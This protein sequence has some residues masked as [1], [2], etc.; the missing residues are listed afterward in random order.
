MGIN[1]GIIHNAEPLSAEC[2]KELEKQV[3]ENQESF[4]YLNETSE[5]C[6]ALPC[7]PALIKY[8]AWDNAYEL[9]TEGTGFTKK[10]YKKT[11]L[12]TFYLDK[13]LSKS[14]INDSWCEPERLEGDGQ[15]FYT[16]APSTLSFRSPAPLNELQDVQINGQTVDPSNYELEE[17]STIVKLKHDYL[18]ALENGKYEVAIISDSMTVKGDFT[19]T[20]PELNEYGFY[21]NQPYFGDCFRNEFIIHFGGPF[22]IMFDAAG[23]A[24]LYQLDSSNA[25]HTDYKLEDGKVSFEFYNDQCD[26]SPFVGSFS[27]DGKTLLGSVV[28][29]SWGTSAT[30]DDIE[31]ALTPEQSACD[32]TYIYYRQYTQY[33]DPDTW[34]Y[35]PITNTL[36]EYPV[37]KKAILDIPVTGIAYEAFQNFDQL[38]SVVIPESVKAIGSYA[39]SSCSMTELTL[40]ISITTLYPYAI[41]YCHSLAR[42]N[43]AGT[44]AQWNAVVKHD[45]WCSTVPATYV[46]CFDGQV[47]L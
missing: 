3:L 14:N 38:Q 7:D 26:S 15:E 21:Y 8:L 20:A 40:P 25:Y 13:V 30:F 16:M 24:H 36:T 37:A 10:A 35:F 23:M 44:V 39:F 27:A 18:S 4:A 22:I 34:E 29:S 2:I 17:G 11:G 47:A 45:D 1:T 9:S 31:L 42:V 43:Y 28:A 5:L 6:F 41:N 19:V 12:E 46:Q 33:A 32:G